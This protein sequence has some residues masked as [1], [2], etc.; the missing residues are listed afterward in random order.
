MAAPKARSGTGGLL[1]DTPAFRAYFPRAGLNF[2]YHELFFECSTSCRCNCDDIGG[3]L[4]KYE[5][6]PL[7]NPRQMYP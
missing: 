1:I 6:V 3:F 7:H 5:D 4:G 2:G